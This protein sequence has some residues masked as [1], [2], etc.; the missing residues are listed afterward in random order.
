VLLT[1]FLQLGSY[2]IYYSGFGNA[3]PSFL[4]VNTVYTEM[5]LERFAGL[6]NDYE[7][8]VDYALFIMAF[9]LVSMINGKHVTLS[10][11]AI[12]CALLIGLFSGTRSFFVSGS[13]F[14]FL[15]GLFT[16]LKHGFSRQ[17]LYF[18]LL[19]S[20]G[21]ILVGLAAAHIIP[22]DVIFDRFYASLLD[23]KTGHY[24]D[25]MNRP[26]LEALPIILNSAGFLGN[27]SVLI[28]KING[29]WTVSH[30]GY[31]A[32]Y[33]SYG[34]AGI[35]FLSYLLACSGYKLITIL[36]RT[37]DRS[38]S[39]TAAVLLALLLSLMAQQVKISAMRML[40]T[41]LLYSF[42]F[43]LIHFKFHQFEGRG[44]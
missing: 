1:P 18:V 37:S 20:A 25:A 4:G 33:A 28:W 38:L 16:L 34:I 43:V 12:L 22:A 3:L 13:I 24:A 2:T 15:L 23:F 9:G 31:L 5:G 11:F 14:I 6:L 35:M 32:V 7:L 8:I 42:L 39:N 40:G 10:F 30:N 19:V 17:L 36:R 21:A 27:G 29:D 44:K 26:I 41:L